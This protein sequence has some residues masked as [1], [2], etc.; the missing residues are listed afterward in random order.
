M[1][2]A[3]RCRKPTG[4]FLTPGGKARKPHAH[5]S[6]VL[7]PVCQAQFRL[8]AYPNPGT[9]TGKLT[10]AVYLSAHSVGRQTRTSTGIRRSGTSRDSGLYGHSSPREHV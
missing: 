7:D 1:C 3:Q 6:G 9:R 8:P 2:G 4:N 10:I 5:R